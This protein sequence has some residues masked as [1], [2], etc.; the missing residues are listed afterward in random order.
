[1]IESNLLSQLNA[2]SPLPTFVEVE[3]VNSINTTV[4]KAFQ[5]VHVFLAE[6]I[7]YLDGL[8]PYNSEIWLFL[9]ILLEHRLLFHADTSFAEMI[10]N[11]RRG[12][13]VSP[14][15]PLPNQGKL[16]W[17][18][19]GP[20]PVAPLEA[21]AMDTPIAADSRAVDEAMFGLKASE[22]LAAG[23]APYGHLKFR[24]L[25]RTQKYITLFLL[26]IKPY[27]R[28]RLNA[29]YEANR[30]EQPG[31][32][33][34]SSARPNGQGLGARVKQ[35]LLRLYPVLCAS[36]EGLNLTFKILFLL[37]LTPYTTP[38]HRLLGIVLRRSTG[39]DLIASSNPRAK[40]A[41]MLGRV[42]IVVLLFG[43][44]LMEFSGVTG[45]V[46]TPEGNSDDLAIP[47]PPEWGVDIVAPPGTPEP[48][49]GI[50]PVCG[51]PVTNA[52]VCAGSGVV[53]CYPCLIQFAREK[54]ACPVTRV[55]M[56]LE[57]VRRI[58]EC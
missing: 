36:W 48:R 51:R 30:E 6:K 19:C 43:F 9:H 50:C 54:G 47:R 39:E 34:L 24:P 15:H 32:Q 1:M 23:S 38:I 49:P 27:L 20:A 4:A 44:R 14:P 55:P 18:L 31:V 28:K 22:I 8:L 10:F 33:P 42:L 11:L 53:G 5:F 35:L 56:S 41:L 17:L 37:E 21:R 46:S 2:A 45:G 7:D 29:W 57:C 16:S 52:A 12:A 58:Y 26:T 40:G 25:S 3:L 13:I